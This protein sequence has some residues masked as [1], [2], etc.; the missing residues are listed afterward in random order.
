MHTCNTYNETTPRVG[1]AVATV[2]HVHDVHL[3]PHGSAPRC[4]MLSNA[5]NAETL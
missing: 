2:A 3:T 5:R 1:V 4:P